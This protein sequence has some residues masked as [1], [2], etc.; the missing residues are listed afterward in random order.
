M[1]RISS[2]TPRRCGTFFLIR[3]EE[4]VKFCYTCN[5]ID[6]DPSRRQE[7]FFEDQ[8]MKPCR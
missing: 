8:T 7:L 4:K 3:P 1:M 5:L 2:P 6:N